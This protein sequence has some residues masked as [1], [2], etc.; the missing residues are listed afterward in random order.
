MSLDIDLEVF[1]KKYSAIYY[2]VNKYYPIL[3]V[4]LVISDYKGAP[5]RNSFVN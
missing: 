5:G 4:G 1:G 3:L 2:V